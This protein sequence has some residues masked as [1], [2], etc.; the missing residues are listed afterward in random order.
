MRPIIGITTYGRYEKDLANPY[1][2]HHFSLPT[3]YID[4]VRRA[5]GLPFLMICSGLKLARPFSEPK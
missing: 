3:L 5:G 4:A 2:E 1:Y